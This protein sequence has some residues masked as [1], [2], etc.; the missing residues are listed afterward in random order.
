MLEPLSESPRISFDVLARGSADRT[1]GWTGAGIDATT[2]GRDGDGAGD[3]ATTREESTDATVFGVAAGGENG[4]APGFSTTAGFCT[5][6]FSTAA[7]LS[8]AGTGRVTGAGVA[9]VA[10]ALATTAGTATLS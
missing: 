8:G 4:S 2:A 9:G 6:G 3:G 5:A 7:P 10:G 1:L